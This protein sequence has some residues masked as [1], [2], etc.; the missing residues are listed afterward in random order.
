M[1]LLSVWIFSHLLRECTLTMK[2]KTF[3]NSAHTHLHTYKSSSSCGLVHPLNFNFFPWVTFFA[4]CRESNSV[5]N[6]W[7]VGFPPREPLRWTIMNTYFHCPVVAMKPQCTDNGFIQS[8][9][10]EEFIFSARVKQYSLPQKAFTWICEESKTLGQ[11][12][13]MCLPPSLCLN[14]SWPMLNT[15]T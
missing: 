5:W 9:V 15:N 6:W 3:P 11:I 1:Q 13:L 4:C 2:M 10:M 14:S 12:R 8:A 7:F